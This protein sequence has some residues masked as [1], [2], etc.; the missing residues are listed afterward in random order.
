[1]EGLGG[2]VTIEEAKN[3][4]IGTL[5]IACTFDVLW[6]KTEADAWIFIAGETV[7]EHQFGRKECSRG[8]SMEQFEDVTAD[9]LKTSLISATSEIAP[10][11][12]C[13]FTDLGHDLDCEYVNSR[14]KAI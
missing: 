14:K 7:F 12:H 3:A 11:C 1:M 5:I 13:S 2:N 9:F 10:E 8:I 6:I 4:P